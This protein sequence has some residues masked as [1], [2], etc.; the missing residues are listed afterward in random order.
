MSKPELTGT[1]LVFEGADYVKVRVEKRTADK[2][3]PPKKTTYG[4]ET[5]TGIKE[6]YSANTVK[7]FQV[8]PPVLIEEPGKEPRLESEKEIAAKVIME[9]FEDTKLMTPLL[10]RV[11]E[12]Y[13]EEK[14]TG[15]K[16][17][18]ALSTIIQ[19]TLN[20]VQERLAIAYSKTYRHSDNSLVATKPKKYL[21]TDV[22]EDGSYTLKLVPIVEKTREFHMLDKYVYSRMLKEQFLIKDEYELYSDNDVDTFKLAKYMEQFYNYTRPNG[23]VIGDAMVVLT[24]IFLQGGPNT[25]DYVVFLYPEKRVL[26]GNVEKFV[27]IMATAQAK[28]KILKG[29]DIPTE[30]EVPLTMSNVPSYR[31]SDVDNLMASLIAEG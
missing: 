20:A 13:D 12:T 4:V 2:I 28:R 10:S 18:E 29:M 16:K 22:K 5:E 17:S 31:Q 19:M 6:V 15:Y 7:Q 25:Q 24:P 21:V 8:R 1:Y 3:N 23:E 11:I 30:G 26:K 27:W 9:Y 14:K